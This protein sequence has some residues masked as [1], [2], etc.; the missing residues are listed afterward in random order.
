[1]V[2]VN[3]VFGRGA[4]GEVKSLFLFVVVEVGLVGERAKKGKRLV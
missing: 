2:D 4:G 1:V 3:L